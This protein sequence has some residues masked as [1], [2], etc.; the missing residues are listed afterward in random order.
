MDQE[1]LT[2]MVAERFVVPEFDPNVVNAAQAE[3][4][5]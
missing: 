3:G 2:E 1:L 4:G 5:E